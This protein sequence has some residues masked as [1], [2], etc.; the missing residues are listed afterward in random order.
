MGVEYHLQRHSRLP[1]TDALLTDE[2]L[3]P[4]TE[5]VAI[6]FLIECNGICSCVVLMSVSVLFALCSLVAIS[7]PYQL[8]R[9]LVVERALVE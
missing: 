7:V 5:V 4:H 1:N 6:I 2:A 3:W 8:P 9:R